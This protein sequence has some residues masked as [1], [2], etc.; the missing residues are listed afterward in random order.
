MTQTTPLAI[1]WITTTEEAPWV[2]QVPLALVAP[3]GM[4]SALVDTSNPQ[5]TIEGCGASFNEFGWDA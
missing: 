5:Q 3:T 4:P 2:E 1:R